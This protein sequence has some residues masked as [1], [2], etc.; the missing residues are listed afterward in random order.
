MNHEL[1]KLLGERISSGL[2]RK[3]VT[4]CSK[5]AEMYR[6]IQDLNDKALIRNWSFKYHPW[7]REMHDCDAEIMVGQKGAQL[8]YSETALNKVFFG[9]DI[10]G[11]SCLYV[12][13]SATPDASN[14]STSRFDPALESSPHLQGLFSDV[15]NIGHKRAG[16]ANL[17]V[18]GSRSRSQLKSVPVGLAII[19][20]VDEMDQKNIP[21]VWERMSG[22]MEKQTFL[23]STPTFEN[24][25][26]NYY[27]RQS[28]QEHFFF[29]CPLCTRMT[30]LIFPDC[31]VIPTDDLTSKDVYDSHI[32]CKE[33]KGKLSH[34]TKWEWLANG[35]WVPSYSD[36]VMRGFHI[37]QLYS[38]TVKPHELAMS[39]LR[40]QTNPGDEQEF[41]NSKLGLPHE[42]DGARIT[43]VDILECTGSHKKSVTPPPMSFLTMGVDVGKWLHYEV[44][45]WFLN[46]D[47]GNDVNLV[48]DCKMIYEG[49]VQHFEELDRLMKDYGITFCVVDA[50]PERRKALE[51]AQRFWGRV[52][53]CFYSNGVTGKNINE[54]S[55]ELHTMSVDRT[56]WMDLSLSRFRRRKISL[57]MDV[58][59]EY[60]VHVKA[61]VR[62]YEKDENGNPIGRYRVGNDE[63]HFA[64][65][66]T[67]SEIALYLGMSLAQ[68][69]DVSGVF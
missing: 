52:K 3:T 5:W 38:S 6:Y 65:A 24:F 1:L 55:E 26:I 68:S 56:S 2:K 35:I 67:Y 18:R 69:H 30:E 37:N 39:Y 61:P 22:Q 45:Q 10:K 27:Y 29:K 62:I 36:R 43:D 54:H 50:N 49:K 15:K 25:G 46:G 42:V 64:H 40:A 57:P 41:Y 7:A 44:D 60:K 59:N 11:V 21:L 53:L 20:E 8:A 47:Q 63:D 31:L 16:S 66:R 14:F 13:P 4:S 48:A 23:L 34:E 58:S 17:F 28:S 19:D 51:F 33:C 32:I 9:I 12:L